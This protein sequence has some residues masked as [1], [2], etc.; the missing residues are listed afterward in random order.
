LLAIAFLN[1][2]L[3]WLLPLI[4]VPIV[5]HLLNRRRFQR[6][7]WAAM[8]FVLAA[9][10]RNRRRLQMQQWLLLLLRTL[11]VLFL[12][13]LVTRPQLQGSAFGAARTHHV[14]ILDDSLSMAHRSGARDAFQDARDA[15]LALSG[16]LSEG[17]SG[18]VI[19]LLTTDTPEKPLLAAQRVG[20]QVQARVR[21][22]LGALTQTND[23]GGDLAAALA[24]ARK[25]GAST[26]ECRQLQITVYSDCRQVDW[27]QPDGQPRPDVVA[28]LQQL[29][30]ETQSLRVVAVGNR[31]AEN[32]AV[33]AVRSKD[34]VVARGVPITLEIEVANRG[35]AA[36]QPGELTVRIGEGERANQRALPLDSIGA[37]QSQT[38]AVQHTFADAGEQGITASLG[39]D[40][41]APDNVRSLAV[42]V[43]AELRCLLVDGD[44]GQRA[45]EAETFYL[46]AVLDPDLEVVTGLDA[47]VVSDAAL[48]DENLDEYDTVWLCNV[49]APTAPVVDKLEKFVA[50]GGGVVVFTGNQVD[51]RR[52]NELFRAGAGGLLPLQLGDVQGDMQ[53]PGRAFLADEEHPLFAA[54][55]EP[56]KSVLASVLVGRYHPSL[57]DAALPLR[58]VLR[59]GDARGPA[60]LVA[61]DATTPGRGRVIVFGTTADDFWCSLVTEGAAFAPICHEIASW[62]VRAQDDRAQ[63]LG[64]RDVYRVQLDGGRYRADATVRSLREAGDE[65]T[66][67]AAAPVDAVSQ[68]VLQLTVPM[69]DLRGFGV[70]ELGLPRLVGERE[71]RLLARNAPAREGELLRLTGAALQRALPAELLAKLKFEE[72]D[73]GAR[74]EDAGGGDLARMLALALVFLLL[75]ESFLAWRASR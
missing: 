34:R 32:L 1:P 31:D 48:A 17:R 73:G 40:A 16:K 44:P 54:V 41:F 68:E 9:L 26:P 7:R 71:V 61:A 35:L 49:P 2:A 53:N 20:A 60:L 59:I 3:L 24:Q 74:G 56:L 22:V 62:V 75:S 28:Q 70:F 45:E 25:L 51:P 27:L 42:K 50:G 15:V 11:A 5:I 65:R 33:A 63:N 57:E 46:S 23:G 64:T 67:T 10:K 12:I 55:A 47:H 13:F 58:P 30:K 39:N 69:A 19:S 66:F 52:Y 4:A 72:S 29:D 38:I 36:S 43:R 37:G 21:E 18:D 14:V 8:E 6:V